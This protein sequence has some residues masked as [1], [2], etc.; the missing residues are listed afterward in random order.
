MADACNLHSALKRV[1]ADREIS[2]RQF[3][4]HAGIDPSVISRLGTNRIEVKQLAAILHHF[5]NDHPVFIE[6]LRAHIWDELIRAGADPVR[7]WAEVA[8]PETG[9]LVNLKP[10]LQFSVR[11]LGEAAGRE[12][13][14]ESTVNGLADIIVRG[15]AEKADASA[16]AALYALPSDPPVRA[17]AEPTP[18]KQRKNTGAPTASRVLP[19][20]PKAS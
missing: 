13:H 20:K 17:V 5:A 14:W 2:A 1:L 7:F 19:P 16:P 18:K 11:V 8:D 9:W 6:L 3:A 12:Q 10:T 15:L 4:L